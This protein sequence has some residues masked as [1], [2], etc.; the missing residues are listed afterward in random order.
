MKEVLRATKVLFPFGLLI[1]LFAA[2]C[3]SPNGG[4]GDLR[5]EILSPLNISAICESG[6][7]NGLFAAWA[8]P[9]EFADLKPP[10]TVE[11]WL[12]GEVI[13]KDESWFFPSPS[14]RF[15]TDPDEP[16][17]LEF[18]FEDSGGRE[19]LFSLSFYNPHPLPAETLYQLGYWEWDCP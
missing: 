1:L 17:K 18:K 8:W 11:W 12:D 16:H 10:Y 15:Q 9:V 14:V 7:E 6:D 2:A 5:L 3:S 4:D 13:K 19:V